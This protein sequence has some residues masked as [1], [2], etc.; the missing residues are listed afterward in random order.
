MKDLGSPT[1]LVRSQPLL[2]FEFFCQSLGRALSLSGHPPATHRE[3][4]HQSVGA[5]CPVCGIYVSGIE[6]F[7]VSQPPDPS[8]ATAKTGRLRLGYCAR[9][10][11]EACTY[12]MTFR[13]LPSLS[14]TQVLARAEQLLA[15]PS[16]PRTHRRH[17]RFF[18]FRKAARLLLPTAALL[19]ILLLRQL[20]LGGEIPLFRQA[21]K[22]QVETSPVETDPR[23][24][25]E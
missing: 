1:I 20:Y 18:P 14:W 25:M 23:A 6:L 21:E 12:R 7:A 13:D 5:E 9:E 4:L 15:S 2:A 22:F 8:L 17:A 10:G 16:H 11:C 24:W 3:L 19:L